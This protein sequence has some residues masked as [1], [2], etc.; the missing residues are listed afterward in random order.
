MASVQVD[1]GKCQGYANCVVTAPD[2]FDIG[3]NGKVV[4][5]FDEILPADR[6]LIEQ[7]VASCPAAALSIGSTP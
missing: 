1:L 4:V 6:A 5:L 3:D 2:A 7:A